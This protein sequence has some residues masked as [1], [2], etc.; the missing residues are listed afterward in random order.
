MAQT[1]ATTDPLSAASPGA[2]WIGIAER[3]SF[4]AKLLRDE[5]RDCLRPWELSE[6]QFSVLWACSAAPP[7]GTGQSE[8]A[9]S[10]AVSPAQISLVVE[11]LRRKRLLTGR[12]DENDRRRQV[13]R[14]SAAGHAVI[15]AVA[16]GLSTW[17]R[18]LGQALG[19]TQI[20][21]FEQ[22]LGA[23][24]RQMATQPNPSGGEADN[25]RDDDGVGS[26]PAATDMACGP[27]ANL[28]REAA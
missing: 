5:F 25:G 1:L 13:W 26:E 28:A 23:L 12:R 15:G 17:A 2:Q 8:L 24:I 3:I 20:A 9:A 16:A 19:E 7:S 22:A 10:L 18:G 6:A 21:A 14:V 4:C 27:N 11:Q